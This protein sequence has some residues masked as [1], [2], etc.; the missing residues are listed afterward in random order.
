MK[1]F[2]RSAICAAALAGLAAGAAHADK[3]R[4]KIASA[5]PLSLVQLGSLAK[6]L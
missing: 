5:Y 1:T 3:V 6:N 4:M 2:I